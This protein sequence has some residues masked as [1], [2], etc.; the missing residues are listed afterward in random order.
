MDQNP[1]REKEVV[2]P[3]WPRTVAAE[4]SHDAAGWRKRN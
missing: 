4:T 3:L 2:F 1:T